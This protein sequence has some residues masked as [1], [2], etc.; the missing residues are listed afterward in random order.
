MLLALGLTGAAWAQ[1]DTCSTAT[2]LAGEG[3]FA[4]DNST[5]SSSGFHGGGPCSTLIRND[6]FFQ[7]TAS[8]GGDY[9][10]DTYGTSFDTRLSVHAGL[11][12]AATCLAS[13]DNAGGGLQS[14]VLLSGVQPGDTFL[15]QVGSFYLF[16]GPGLLNVT[17]TSS[18]CTG[19]ADDAWE[20]NQGCAGAVSLPQG[21]TP[22][23]AVFQ[24]NPDYYHYVLQPGQRLD[25][26][27]LLNAPGDVD[28]RLFDNN[29]TPLAEDGQALSVQNLD[30]FA[31]DYYLEAFLDTTSTT[32]PCSE[33]TLLTNVQSDP[34]YGAA[35]DALEDNDQ[36]HTAT[37]LVDGM[38]PN[39]HVSKWDKDVY[40]LCVPPQGT[41]T[42][43]LL[44]AHAQ[45]DVDMYL[46]PTWSYPCAIGSAG[47]Y[48]EEGISISDNEQIVWTNGSTQVEECYLEV[49]IFEG[50]ASSCNQ[51]DLV[52]QGAGLCGLGERICSPAQTNS[53]GQS[54]QI[55]AL[56]SPFVA[57]GQLTLQVRDLPFGQ[58]GFCLGGR[59]Q[60]ILANPGGSLGDLCLSGGGAI[61]RFNRSWEIGFAANG[62]FE[63]PIDLDAIPE[64][65]VGLR[66][67]QA[68]ETW[69]FQAWYRDLVGGQSVSNF[70]D[71]IGV[72]Y[73]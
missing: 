28:L 37:T 19:Q 45:G 44:F 13:N 34:C 50:S 23:L 60:G 65:G 31:R 38:R 68:G 56:G 30:S 26:E 70:T 72:T 7:W 3:S 16:A 66:A 46:L 61:A 36:C 41:V 11:G 5:A 17:A 4:F 48:Y 43:D 47:F 55:V 69:Y 25:A 24:G 9:R 59:T 63:V 35:E 67:V 39:L 32:D 54:G 2:A 33:Y 42:I 40:R 8:A 71:A 52:L 73:R 29:C 49:Q 57:D 20:P 14:E 22:G 51:Y 64:P 1:G 27:I 18:P 12:C 21:T 62:E 6:V 53:S 58:F 15:V 10:L